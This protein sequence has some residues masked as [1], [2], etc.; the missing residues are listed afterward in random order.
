MLM[1]LQLFLSKE[2]INFLYMIKNK[3]INIKKNPDL[4]EKL[5]TF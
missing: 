1:M 4:K 2:I 5:G 3:A